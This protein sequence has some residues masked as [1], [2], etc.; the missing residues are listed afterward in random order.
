LKDIYGINVVITHSA[1]E[2][3]YPDN[4][5]GFG[6]LVDEFAYHDKQL[7]KE[8]ILLRCLKSWKVMAMLS[9]NIIMDIFIQVK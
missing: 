7:L 2:W 9:L 6:D 5:N 8:Q 3:C 4:R 1:P